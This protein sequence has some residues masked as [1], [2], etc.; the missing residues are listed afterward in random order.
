MKSQ[1]LVVGS[2]NADFVVRVG[3]FPIPGQ[4]IVGE[5]FKVFPGGKGANQAY[6]AAKLGGRVSMIGQVGG[7]AHGQWLKAHLSAAGVDVSGVKADPGATSGIAV[8]TT[9]RSGQNEIIIVPGANGAFTPDRLPEAERLFNEAGQVLLQLEIPMATTEAAVRLSRKA[10]AITL[11]DPAPAPEG[12]LSEVLLESI[13]YLTPNETELAILTGAP[14]V[15]ME[16]PQAAALAR[17]LLLRGPR[18]IIVKLGAQGALLVSKEVEHFWPAI[19]TKAVD[20]T[21]AGDA[22]NGAF[23]VAL[24][25]GQSVLDAGRYAT[26]AAACSVARAGAQPSMPTDREVQALLDRPAA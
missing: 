21:A 7:D 4:T 16:V 1:I 24:A 23:A 3:S 20:T 18:N 8:I 6:A 2:L 26:A 19:R 15:A 10:G 22:F 12:G 25:S 5:E 11:L 17:K 13:D 14:A 9:D